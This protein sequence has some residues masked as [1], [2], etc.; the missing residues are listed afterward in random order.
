MIRVGILSHNSLSQKEK[1]TFSG[2]ELSRDSY[3]VRLLLL[4]MY[5]ELYS[6]PLPK[7]ECTEKGKPYL[8]GEGEPYISL[9]H[10]DGY[11]AVCLCDDSECGVDIE[12]SQNELR[13]ARI[14]DRYLSKVNYTLHYPSCECEI[15]LYEFNTGEG[16]SKVSTASLPIIKEKYEDI[17]GARNFSVFLSHYSVFESGWTLV[18]AAL[19][20]S[21]KGFLDFPVVST[22]LES[23]ST[24]SLAAH[25]NTESSEDKVYLSLAINDTK[26]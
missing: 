22:L 5:E 23:Y 20:C 10:S 3:S 25:I 17:S 11:S 24:L 21:G 6:R 8:S 26:F 9:S 16:I 18:E 4:S 7:I 15:S 14:T 19:K 1:Y 2:E 13:R 12:E